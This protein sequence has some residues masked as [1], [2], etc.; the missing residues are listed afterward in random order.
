MLLVTFLRRLTLI[1]ALCL[2]LALAAVLAAAGFFYL[3]A[4]YTGV[5]LRNRGAL[6]QVREEFLHTDPLFDNF[7]VVLTDSNGGEVTCL[8]RAPRNP[9]GRQPAILA[10]DG[11]DWGKKVVSLFEDTSYAVLISFDWPDDKG[12]RYQ[13]MNIG[14]FL[15]H[16]RRALMRMV[17]MVP[18]VVDYL[19]RRPDVDPEKILV[20]GASLGV[21]IAV[22][23]AAIDPRLRAAILLYG[24]GNLTKLAEHGARATVPQSWKRKV[25]G[26]WVGAALAPVEPLKYV[27][28]ISPRPVLMINGNE[29]ESI[30]RECVLAL[31][32]MA[33]EPK[34][35]IWLETSHVAPEMKE[36]VGR[37]EQIVGQWSEEHNLR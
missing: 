8:V 10:I 18:V 31:Y 28:R 12:T 36:L 11:Y 17:S 1:R 30:P 14:P 19:E 32:G 25:M 16:I 24:G 7:Q 21:P 37:M 22:D 27:G 5:F 26:W 33:R 9:R 2:L 3:R 34:E 23:A 6:V 35:L 15:V 20:V 29:D 13:G 4:D